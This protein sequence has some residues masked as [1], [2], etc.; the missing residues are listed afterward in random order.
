MKYRIVADKPDNVG[1][2]NLK[3]EVKKSFFKFWEEID[4]RWAFH[5]HGIEK[6]IARVKDCLTDKAK[7][8]KEFSKRLAN[9]EVLDV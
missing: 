4:N 2:V 5:S 6:D 9:V 8:H 7:E 3:L 1:D